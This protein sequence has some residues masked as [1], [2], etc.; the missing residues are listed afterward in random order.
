M[1]TKEK[2]KEIVEKFIKQKNISYTKLIDEID[3]IGL[4]KNDVNK[5]KLWKNKEI[6]HGKRKGET[7]DIYT[8][9]YSMMGV[10]EEEGCVVS[11]DAHSGEILYIQAHH[12][13]LDIED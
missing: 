5:I 13:Y 6:L 2:V 9:I 4:E 11:I 7:T 8:Y 10:Q 3:F 1:I 12:W